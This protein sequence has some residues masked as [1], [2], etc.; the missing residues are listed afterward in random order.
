M[1]RLTNAQLQAR[2]AELEAAAAAAGVSVNASNS[3]ASEE[4]VIV[5]RK[6]VKA[7]VDNVIVYENS[8]SVY[9]HLEKTEVILKQQE[10]GADGRVI[11]DS[12]LINRKTQWISVNMRDIRTNAVKLGIAKLML[13]D[14]GK[15]SREVMSAFIGAWITFSI[16]PFS[17]GD[18]YTAYDGTVRQYENDGAV[19]RLLNASIDPKDFSEAYTMIIAKRK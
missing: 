16:T 12:P 14:Y 18:D 15:L 8:G 1:S 3:E 13:V 9:L 2:I 10:R 6:A 4:L 17:A 7:K 19:V 5:A 11:D